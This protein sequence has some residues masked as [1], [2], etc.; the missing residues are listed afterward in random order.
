[1]VESLN[2]EAGFSNHEG[3]GGGVRIRP[4]SGTGIGLYNFVDNQCDVLF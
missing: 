4:P 3:R 2:S 1:V